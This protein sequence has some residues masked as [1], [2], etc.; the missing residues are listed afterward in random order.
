M[1]TDPRP[2][3]RRTL[4]DP[5]ALHANNRASAL[6][7]LLMLDLGGVLFPS[8]M[9]GI[10]ADVA[11]DVGVD[12][13]RVRRHVDAALLHALWGGEVSID[14]FW[15]R[16]ASLSGAPLSPARRAR[17]ERRVAARMRPLPALRCLPDWSR[18]VRIGVLS[19]HRAEWARPALARAG[20][21][22]LLDPL[23]ISS[24]TGCVKPDADAFAQLA[25]LGVAPSRILYVDDRA[26]ARRGAARVGVR[27]RA[28]DP[29][30]R[31]APDLGLL[32]AGSVRAP[33]G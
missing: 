11:S 30:G 16:I 27:T 2:A 12:R 13:E 3:G 25:R 22:D 28:A 19:N 26:A 5:V 24:E 17:W 10:V 14:V 20:V 33:T 23:L 31:W 21:L 6:P 15:A 29:A 32:L 18:R 8:V 4:G 7:E 9:P 1:M